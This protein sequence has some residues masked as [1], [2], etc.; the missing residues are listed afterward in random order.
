MEISISPDKNAKNKPKLSLKNTFKSAKFEIKDSYRNKP[1]WPLNQ[2][3]REQYE[4]RFVNSSNRIYDKIQYEYGSKIVGCGP[5]IRLVKRDV[6]GLNYGEDHLNGEK[7][8]LKPKPSM[9][10]NNSYLIHS[11]KNNKK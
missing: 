10:H 9:D 8:E 6:Q 3:I 5:K 4:N 1:S 7:Y 11:S 2:S